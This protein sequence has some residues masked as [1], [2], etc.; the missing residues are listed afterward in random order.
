MN[1]ERKKHFFR[2]LSKDGSKRYRRRSPDW[3]E[4][5]PVQPEPDWEMRL[6]RRPLHAGLERLPVVV[7]GN[8]LHWHWTGNISKYLSKHKRCRQSQK[9]SVFL[10][11]LQLKMMFCLRG[12]LLRKLDFI[13]RP[14]TKSTFLITV[15][16]KN[17]QHCLVT[18]LSK[19]SLSLK[20]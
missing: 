15:K 17:M 16:K 20:W 2:V 9:Y 14:S 12:R 1:F 11:A 10:R 13:R 4:R 8:F 3:V 7:R 18:F 19:S 5:D 6:A